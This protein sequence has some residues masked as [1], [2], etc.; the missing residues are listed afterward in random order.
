MEVIVFADPNCIYCK[1]LEQLFAQ[2]DDI[3]IYTF[4]IPLLGPESEEKSKQILCS[5]DQATTWTNW[6]RKGQAPKDKGTCKTPLDQI[7]AMGQGLNIQ[8]SPVVIFPNGK[9]IVGMPAQ[10]LTELRKVITDHQK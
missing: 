4:L 7:K 3:T 10:D 5:K 9:L 8:G 1:K 2:M 6:M